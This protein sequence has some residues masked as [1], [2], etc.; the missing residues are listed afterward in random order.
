MDGGMEEQGPPS[1]CPRCGSPL[2]LE[3]A[4]CPRCGFPLGASEEDIRRQYECYAPP[5][6]PVKVKSSVQTAREVMRGIGAVMTLIILGL[7]TINIGIMLWGMGLVIPEAW[8]SV[9]SL[10]VAVPWLVRF[11]SLPGVWFVLFYILLVAAVLLSFLVMLYLGRREMLKEMG[12]RPTRHSGA[13]AVGT[14]FLAVLTMNTA[15]YLLIGLFGIDPSTG[16]SA[17]S[18]LWELM[19]SLLRASVWEEVIC[20]ILYIGLPLA[21]VYAVKGGAA[22]YRR[23]VLGGNFRFGPWEKVFL[24]FSSS[25]FALAHVF[26]WDLWKVPPTFV[27]GLALGYLF[28]RYGVYAS[29]MLH[30]T[31]DYLSMPTEVWPG[32]GTDIALGLFLLVAM[33]VGV[34]Y[35]GYYSIRAL[36]LFSGRTILRWEG[37]TPASYYQFP[38]SALPYEPRPGPSYGPSFGFVCK[39]CGGTEARYVDGRFQCTRCGKES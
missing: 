12:F 18:Q 10:Y 34:V 35:L 17:G 33:L 14:L 30:F 9:T 39:Y 27:A 25:M 24:I 32:E 36:E 1:Y 29:I 26:S 23:Y 4:F 38:R 16:G 7:V 8:D 15:Y 3:A 13:Y 22:P 21:V 5:P 11:L 28:L 2:P 37:R 31:I 19:Y 20:R 6:R